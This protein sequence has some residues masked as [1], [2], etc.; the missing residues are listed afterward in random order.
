MLLNMYPRAACHRSEMRNSY[1]DGIIPIE[2]PDD[3]Q[4]TKQKHQSNAFY[5]HFLGSATQFAP[6]QQQQEQLIMT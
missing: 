2:H 6:Q 4:S 1:A 5:E 3:S